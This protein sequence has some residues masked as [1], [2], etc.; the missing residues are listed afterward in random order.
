[1]NKIRDLDDGVK[2]G[3][4]IVITIILFGAMIAGGLHWVCGYEIIDAIFGGLFLAVIGMSVQGMIA[5]TLMAILG[6]GY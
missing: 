2:A 1:M 5:I 6:V 3:L 4:L